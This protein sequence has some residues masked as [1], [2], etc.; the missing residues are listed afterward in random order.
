MDCGYNVDYL[1]AAMERHGLA[2]RWAYWDAI[3][4]VYH[5]LSANG[6]GRSMPRRTG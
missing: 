6:S 2:G 5:G 4:D 1:R 3:N